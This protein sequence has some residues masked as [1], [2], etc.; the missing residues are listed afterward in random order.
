MSFAKDDSLS[1][2]R[3][4]ERYFLFNMMNVNPIDPGSF[5]AHQLHSTATSTVDRIVIE[6]FI[7][8]IA[9]SLGVVPNPKD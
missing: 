7:T 4:S 9:R 6:G 2:P 1:V 8:T 3:L 5:L